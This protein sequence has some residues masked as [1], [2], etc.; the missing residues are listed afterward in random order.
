[1]AYENGTSNLSFDEGGS[2]KHIAFTA[3]YLRVWRSVD[4][5]CKEAAVMFE[6]EGND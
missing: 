4:G 2:G 1:M 5:S 6:P 3:A